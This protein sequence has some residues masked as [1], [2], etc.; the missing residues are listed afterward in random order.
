MTITNNEALIAELTSQNTALSNANST[1][2]ADNGILDE[3]IAELIDPVQIGYLTV[4]QGENDA[5]IAANDTKIAANDVL[6]SSL[7]GQN[8]ALT[9]TNATLA[10]NNVILAAIIIEVTPN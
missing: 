10:A 5:A 1:L 4:V 3:I 8:T 7:N 6:I 2:T 9:T